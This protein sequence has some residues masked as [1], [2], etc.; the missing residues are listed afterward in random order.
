MTHLLPPEQNPIGH[1]VGELGVLS[2]DH[3]ALAVRD[4]HAALPRYRV[5]R[6][7]VGPERLNDV[8]QLADAALSERQLCRAADAVG[9]FGDFWQGGCIT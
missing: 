4:I 9:S 5:W 6:R 2:L 3:T 8:L 1:L 7:A